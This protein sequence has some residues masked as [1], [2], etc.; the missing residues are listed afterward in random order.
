M[1]LDENFLTDLKFKNSIEDV[2]S[3]FVTLKRQGNRLTGL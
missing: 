1:P 2:I 3:E